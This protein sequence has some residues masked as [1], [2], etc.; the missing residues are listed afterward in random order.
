MNYNNF[1]TQICRK[2][3]LEDHIEKEW[4]KQKTIII[5]LTLVILEDC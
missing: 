1:C 3:N 2:A 5:V 4:V